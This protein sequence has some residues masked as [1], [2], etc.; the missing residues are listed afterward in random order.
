MKGG[1][2]RTGTRRPFEQR[3][4]EGRAGA[5]LRFTEA[6]PLAPGRAWER[7]LGHEGHLFAPTG[8]EDKRRGETKGGQ[9]S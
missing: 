6:P 7:G 5:C 3:A 4:Q 8:G 2:K 1:E 9:A